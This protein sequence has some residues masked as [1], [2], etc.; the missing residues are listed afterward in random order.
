MELLSHLSNI[1]P[2]RMHILIAVSGGLDSMVL[3]E[4]LK[5]TKLYIS[6]VHANFQLRYSDSKE[7][8]CFIKDFCKHQKIP[9]Y[10]KKFK[11]KTYSIEKKKSIQMAARSLRYGWFFR[12]LKD[13]DASYIVLGHHLDD[14]IETF[15]MNLFRSSNLKGLVSI[16][17]ISKFLLRPLL[18]FT[19]T[20]IL[21]FA[22]IN[23][24]WW[25]ED[26]S[27]QDFK[28]LRNTIRNDLITNYYDRNSKTLFFLRRDYILIQ[29]S[30]SIIFKIITIIFVNYTFYWEL[31]TS[32]LKKIKP[33]NGYLYRLFS[34]YGF[35]NLLDIERFL[36]TS[37]GKH[38]YSKRYRLLHYRRRLVFNYQQERH[39]RYPF[40]FH[41]E[42]NDFMDHKA[43]ISIDFSIIS[44]PIS[45]RNW[46]KGDLFFTSL[47][48]KK[49]S[50]LLKEYKLSIFEKEE[51][52]ILMNADKK[53]ICT[54]NMV[55]NFLFKI[56]LKTNMILNIF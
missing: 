55:I 34:P 40:K 33:L 28:Y 53:I 16:P 13:I 37:T 6:V 11:T 23:N 3:L 18:P 31:N 30:I 1:L 43:L 7:D 5:Y 22:N 46:K 56:T 54:I 15:F 36:H 47:R 10:N 17:E 48:K 41:L 8:E 38:I 19:K 50:K 25:R 20:K 21:Q 51:I 2:L 35:C 45:L 26:I 32:K 44:W 49:I 39:K 42:V 24:I 9:F 29:Q 14:T 52:F 27:N 4:I 12:I